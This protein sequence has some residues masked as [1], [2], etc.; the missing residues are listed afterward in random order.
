VVHLQLSAYIG[1][2]VVE[3][4]DIKER[5]HAITTW[6][7]IGEQLRLL[8]NYNGVMI[9]ISGL[10]SA[11]VFRMKKTWEVRQYMALSLGRARSLT[12]EASFCCEGRRSA[13]S[14]V[15]RTRSWHS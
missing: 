10:T 5:A 12:N 11:P 13:V 15:A 4:A 7:T 1:S 8:N 6:I 2:S 14:G 9:V 3:S